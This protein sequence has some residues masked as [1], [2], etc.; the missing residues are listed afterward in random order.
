MKTCKIT[1][2]LLAVCM[3]A[4]FIGCEKKKES[5][6][7]P[8]YVIMVNAMNGLSVYEQQSE[9]ARK[10]AKDYGIK[11]EITGPSTEDKLSDI[12]AI[13]EAYKTEMKNA[14]AKKPDA[15]ICEPFDSEIYSSVTEA[16]KAGIPVFCTSNG[17][18]TAED[19]ISCIGTDNVEYGKR[20]ADLL[21][22]KMGNKASVLAVLSE[23][24]SQNQT[25]QLAEFKKQCAEKYPEIVVADT[26][27]DRADVDTAKDLFKQKFAENS[28]INAVLML[29]SVGG[30]VAADVAKEMQKDICI[31]DVDA[32][33]EKIEKIISGEEWATLAQNFFKRGYEAVR[34]A[35]EY[36][37]KDGKVGFA[38]FEDSSVV[39]I[40]KENAADYEQ[41]LWDTVRTKGTPWK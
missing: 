30:T 31:L 12:K 2:L 9:A 16:K 36:V 20:A 35:Y 3:M 6:E 24:N 41:A 40:T 17:T 38:D 23:E 11:L 25:V 13:I 22:E 37:T 26:I 10:A 32:T 34:M 21:A 28:K 8:A 33:K 19:Y 1:A 4:T 7:K 27:S 5:T 14:I 39:L 15:I 29:E 18:E